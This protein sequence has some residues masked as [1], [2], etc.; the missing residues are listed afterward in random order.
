MRTYSRQ[1]QLDAQAIVIDGLNASINALV[2]NDTLCQQVNLLEEEL[3]GSKERCVE[4]DAAI[5]KVK[6][7]HFHISTATA[8]TTSISP[9]CTI[10][11][12]VACFV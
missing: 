2:E 6:R 9:S 1:G 5:Q 12:C 8:R 4:G 10:L 11:H 3:A 7:A